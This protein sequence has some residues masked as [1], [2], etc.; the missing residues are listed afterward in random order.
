MFQCDARFLRVI[1]WLTCAC[2]EK[3]EVNK[4]GTS[5]GAFMS[6]YLSANPQEPD[7]K[8]LLCT[9]SASASLP[10]PQQMIE[11]DCA[12]G[13]CSD[14]IKGEAADFEFEVSGAQHESDADGDQVA[15]I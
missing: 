4:K 12:D 15:R 6:E 1:F 7:F 13:C 11:D 9:L 10:Q 14:A 3:A 2:S 8:A 5:K